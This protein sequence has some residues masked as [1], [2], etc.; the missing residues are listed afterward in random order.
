[1]A[2]TMATS[3]NWPSPV[4]CAWWMAASRPRAAIS[5]GTVS[6]MGGPQRSRCSGSVPVED[7][8]PPMAWAIGS[9]AGQLA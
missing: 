8:M 5:P 1:M 4:R 3:M 2:S 6:P 9:N 7:T